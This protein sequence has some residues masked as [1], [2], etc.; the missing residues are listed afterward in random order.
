MVCGGAEGANCWY[1]EAGGKYKDFVFKR[2]PSR[3]VNSAKYFW[4]PLA[5]LDSVFHFV[6]QRKAQRV[7]LSQRFLLGWCFTWMIWAGYPA[8]LLHKATC[9]PEKWKLTNWHAYQLK[10]QA[11]SLAISASANTGPSWALLSR[12]LLLWTASN[13]FVYNVGW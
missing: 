2:N 9:S 7:N 5:V 12:G 6:L 3:K 13:D 11:A 4:G 10:G 8:G 1:C